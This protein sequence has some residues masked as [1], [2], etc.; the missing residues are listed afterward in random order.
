MH[1]KT[2]V[3]TS[4]GKWELIMLP[5]GEESCWLSVGVCSRVTLDDSSMLKGST[6]RKKFHRHVL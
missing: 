3:L 1:E 2:N 4:R 5:D 6:S